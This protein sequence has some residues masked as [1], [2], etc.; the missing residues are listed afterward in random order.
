MASRRMGRRGSGSQR[1]A[2]VVLAGAVALVIAA[3]GGSGSKSTSSGGGAAQAGST[4]ITMWHGYGELAAP[5][6]EKNYELDSLQTLVKKFEA[7]HPNDHGQPA[8]T[9]TRTTRSRS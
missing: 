9:S 6:E 8:R 4:E 2:L 5:G 3:C 7:T 1:G